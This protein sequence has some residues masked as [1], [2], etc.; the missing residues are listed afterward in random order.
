MASAGSGKEKEGR[1]RAVSGPWG[2]GEGA[3]AA[4]ETLLDIEEATSWPTI[5]GLNSSP[6]PVPTSMPLLTDS[7]H[8][9]TSPNPPEHPQPLKLRPLGLGRAPAPG[10]RRCRTGGEEGL[11]AALHFFMTE[12]FSEAQMVISLR[13]KCL[14]RLAIWEDVGMGNEALPAPGSPLCPQHYLVNE[15]LIFLFDL[16]SHGRPREP[17]EHVLQTHH[18]PV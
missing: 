10:R 18:V 4:G 15:L 3:W 16:H 7:P 11:T 12:L 9:L 6:T 13:P 1:G 8:H 2:S 17:L 14:T 5:Q